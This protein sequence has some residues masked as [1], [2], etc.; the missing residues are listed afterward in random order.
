MQMCGPARRSVSQ[1]NCRTCNLPIAIDAPSASSAWPIPAPRAVRWEHSLGQYV[2]R[3]VR[4]N[5]AGAGCCSRSHK[6][7]TR[8]RRQAHARHT[9]RLRRQGAANRLRRDFPMS[10]WPSGLP[11][12]SDFRIEQ[13]LEK[14]AA[15]NRT[16]L[17]ALLLAR[18]CVIPVCGRNPRRRCVEPG[19][20]AMHK[21]G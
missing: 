5:S 3:D 15:Y 21:I 6:L 7:P 12:R 13:C 20:E 2:R 19:D 4:Q 11:M 14:Y 10:L 8:K 18:N 17:K 9:T 1:A 16:R